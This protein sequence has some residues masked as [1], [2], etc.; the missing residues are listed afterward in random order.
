MSFEA[1]T[2]SFEKMKQLNQSTVLN[3]IR[4]R[5]PISRAEIAKL[6]KLTPPTVSSL[7]N[8]LIQ[9][10]L[11]TE[12][13]APSSK[14][15]GRKPIMLRINYS[16]YYIVGVYAAAEI[17]RVILTTMDG[18]IISDYCKEMTELPSKHEF[19]N[20]VIESIH[21]VLNQTTIDKSLILGIGF[22]MH[23]LVNPNEGL[24]IFS[25]HLQLENIPIKDC[26]EEEF[27]IP[28]F[29]E[30]DV[31]ALALAESWF[32]QG[33][34]VSDFV[35]ISVGRGI[36]SGI[37]INSE[38]YKSSFNTG[39]EI[40]HTIID[41]NGP[42]CQCGNHGCLEAYASETAI[43]SKVKSELNNYPDSIL[44][45]WVKNGK[46]ELS[47]NLVFDAARSGDEL[48]ASILVETGR[49][50]G[51][52]AANMINILKPSKL[53]LEGNIFL[54]DKYVLDPLKQ[55]INKYTF[56]SPH[57]EISVVCSKLGKTGMPLG[58]VTLVLNKLF[59]PEE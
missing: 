41:V 13:E 11:V 47:L 49:S 25:P 3:M 7:V 6:T 55:M 8:E 5:E 35:C 59:K 15:G 14:A 4:I 51:L 37:F 57:E 56:K 53:I 33:K 48:A 54:E 17:I 18:K 19:L 12:E 22:A 43:L 30:N 28:V 31:R 16:A 10:N 21:Y 42:K 38:I 9:K 46:K 50:L 2:G 23:G 39:G 52:A 29:V 45:Q 58:A 36:G 20:L 40:G 1:K 24:A 44:F 27:D 32:G 34:D 26:L